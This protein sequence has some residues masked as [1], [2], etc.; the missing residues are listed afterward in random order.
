[1]KILCING[2]QLEQ[3]PHKYQIPYQHCW[4]VDYLREKGNSVDTIVYD[5]FS[6]NRISNL[7]NR[8][9][10]NLKLLH[11][12]RNYDI[13]LS[14]YSPIIDIL[15]I[16]KRIGLTNIKLF[17]FVHHFGKSWQVNSSFNKIFFISKPVMRLYDNK[18]LKLKFIEW[19]PDLDFYDHYIKK[20][21]I[22]NKLCFV[23][24]GRTNRDI[25][26]I[27]KACH[28]TES[29]LIIMESNRLL[30]DDEIILE[31]KQKTGLLI[32]RPQMVEYMNKAQVSLI[33]VK[34]DFSKTSLCGLNSFIEA[35]ALGQPIIMSD[36]TNIEVDIEKLKIGLLY[37]A[38]DLADLI[39]KINFFKNNPHLINEYSK[40]AR[41]YAESHSYIHYCQ[42][43]YN[44]IIS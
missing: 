2:Y 17:T 37:K 14:F 32:N 13:I 27:R 40:N 42:D 28:E 34:K 41:K 21:E 8:I 29:S 24:N 31:R 38:G 5:G 16:F 1:M 23:S 6:P 3:D 11:K 30:I 44:S 9:L 19:G 35:L 18:G 39:D 43:L 20:S 22:N 7:I 10:F 25:D 26:I 33:S 36:N 12:S 15:G 4:G